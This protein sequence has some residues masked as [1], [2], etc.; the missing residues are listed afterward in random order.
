[1]A[2]RI[3]A[4]YGLPRRANSPNP[5]MFTD[6]MKSPQVQT[7]LLHS[8]RG[9]EKKAMSP[10]EFNEALM[11]IGETFRSNNQSFEEQSQASSTIA[12]EVSSSASSDSINLPSLI[13][14]STLSTPGFP[15]L[16]SGYL[17]KKCKD[18]NFH[19]LVVE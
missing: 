6:N 13:S 14:T 10:N 1:M 8:P 12:S 17:H 16:A 18:I 3:A 15:L 5:S 2:D 11:K 9:N 19:Y 7:G 4:K